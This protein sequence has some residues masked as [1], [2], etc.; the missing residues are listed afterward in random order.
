MGAVGDVR[1][2]RTEIPTRERTRMVD[3]LMAGIFGGSGR[4]C[5]GGRRMDGPGIE[6]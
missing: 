4:A 6:V 3:G 1:L 2:P 5:V